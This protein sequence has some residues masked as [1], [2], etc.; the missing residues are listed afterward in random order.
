MQKEVTLTIECHSRMLPRLKPTGKSSGGNPEKSLDAR[1]GG[2][3]SG[4]GTLN[5]LELQ[6]PN[7][8]VSFQ[9]GAME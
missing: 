1:E 5:C 3:T 6:L 4:N 2:T 8:P 7:L 9:F